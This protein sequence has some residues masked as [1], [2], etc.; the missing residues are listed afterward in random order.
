[1]DHLPLFAVR[2]Y[3]N[4][5]ERCTCNASKGNT[6]IQYCDI[7]RFSEEQFKLTLE[8][9]PWDTVF[10]FDEIDDM[11]ESWENLF[12]EALDLHCPW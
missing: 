9:I 12:N 7:R 3:N 4:A 6:F 5:L 11:L 8:Q 1:M 10:V 2:T